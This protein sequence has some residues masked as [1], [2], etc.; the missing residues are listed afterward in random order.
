MTSAAQAQTR[1][2][3]LTSEA[4]CVDVWT[5]QAVAASEELRL[6]ADVLKLAQKRRW[7]VYVDVNALNPVTLAL[8]LFRNAVGAGKLQE[9]RITIKQIE[10]RREEVKARLRTH[11]FDQLRAYEGSQRLEAQA[12]TLWEA[13]KAL[14]AVLEVGYTRGD[15]STERMLPVWEKRDFY[16]LDIARQKQTQR[17]I[18]ANLSILITSKH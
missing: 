7:T 4:A 2:D 1:P 11:L 9:Q 18:L 13:Q 16:A 5:T 14:I 15:L 3:C 10:L 12:R 6:L 8:Q 17:D